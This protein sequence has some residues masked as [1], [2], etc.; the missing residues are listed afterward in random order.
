MSFDRVKN[1]R[2]LILGELQ[3]ISRRVT[4]LCC[5]TMVLAILLG[6]SSY[7]NAQSLNRGLVL[8]LDF[9][10]GLQD[11]SGNGNDGQLIGNATYEGDRFGNGCSALTLNGSDAFV[12]IPSSRSLNVRGNALTISAWVKTRVGKI[13]TYDLNW[14]TICSK[15]NRSIETANS[16][17]Y[18]FQVSSKTI[19]LNTD[20]TEN[21][22]LKL[23]FNTWFHCVL[24]YDG[25]MVRA[26]V[27]NEL[28]MQ[29]AY[30][31]RLMP[32]GDPLEIGRDV[33]GNLEMHHGSLD[34]LRIYNRVLSSS[35][36]STLYYQ[37]FQGVKANCNGNIRSQVADTVVVYITDTITIPK[38]DTL[39]VFKTDTIRVVEYDSIPYPVIERDTV[40]QVQDRLVRDTVF[41]Q[42]PPDTVTYYAAPDTV[43]LVKYDTVYVASKTP[44]NDLISP[45]STFFSKGTATVGQ[46]L[47][48]RN[49]GFVK[50]KA[51]LLPG[52]EPTLKRLINWLNEN[53]DVVI[54]LDGHTDN[55]GGA[56]PLYELSLKR[57]EAVKQILL[58]NGIPDGRLLTEGF[59]GSMPLNGNSSQDKKEEN[60][61]VEVT[62]IKTRNR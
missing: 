16:P 52:Y 6:F 48:L 29:Q 57:A 31:G 33:P 8:N 41:I 42:S 23:D 17:Q 58:A 5:K 13:N 18:R 30:S 28:V 38:V 62:I 34:D 32:N 37:T 10:K 2:K 54:R 26:Y 46:R 21:V 24:T 53:P 11:V 9:N 3:N 59:G 43:T 45:E 25:R 39:T 50:G 19:S 12:R 51:D 35:E 49:V 40:I 60:R 61:R 20:I 56:Q 4:G 7:I 22:N 1:N 44:D 36:I 55:F 47:V 15:G 14:L 27:N